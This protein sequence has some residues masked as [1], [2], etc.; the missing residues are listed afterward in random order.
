MIKAVDD[1]RLTEPEVIIRLKLDFKE[2]KEYEYVQINKRN[3]IR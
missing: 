1:G 2:R 3:I